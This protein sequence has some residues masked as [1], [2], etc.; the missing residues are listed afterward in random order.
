M[1]LRR[2]LAVGFVVIAATGLASLVTQPVAVGQEQCGRERWAVKTLSDPA[3]GDIDFNPVP[4]GVDDLRAL[5]KPAVSSSTPRIPGTETTTYSIQA[6]LLRMRLEV[7]RDIHLVIADPSDSTHTMIVELPDAGCSEAISS[8]R[9]S[10]MASARAAFIAACGEPVAGHVVPLVGS[11]TITGVGFFDVLHGQDGVAPNGV[12]LHPVLGLDDLVCNASGAPAPVAPETEDQPQPAAEEPQQQAPATTQPDVLPAV[13]TPGVAPAAPAAPV[14]T[15]TRAPAPTATSS[16]P[17][18]VCCRVCT[19][20][21]A[22]GNSCIAANLT[23]H[24]PPGCACNGLAPEQREELGGGVTLVP[25]GGV[26]GADYG[27]QQGCLPADGEGGGS[28]M[29]I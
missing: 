5:G 12:E 24:Q 6:I 27:D 1:S 21:K 13:T 15:A 8:A 3:A 29:A 2:A 11:A 18:P 22:C 20:G 16:P 25:D 14:P 26:F 19:T 7:D 28:E 4:A 23:C 9:V 17:G 10:D